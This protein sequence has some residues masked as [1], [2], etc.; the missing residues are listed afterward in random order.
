MISKFLGPRYQQLAKNWIPVLA[1]WSAVGSVG[2]ILDY[3]PYI[4]G[5]FKTDD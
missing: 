2:L 3:V 4:S 5:K 1:T